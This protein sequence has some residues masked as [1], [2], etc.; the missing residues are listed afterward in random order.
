MAWIFQASLHPGRTYFCWFALLK[1][2]I[3]S[4][5]MRH[6]M[7]EPHNHNW[8]LHRNCL[9]IDGL[10]NSSVLWWSM[11]RPL[12]DRKVVVCVSSKWCMCCSKNEQMEHSHTMVQFS[13]MTPSYAYILQNTVPFQ[14]LSQVHSCKQGRW[15]RNQ[16]H[17]VACHDIYETVILY[18]LI[19][20][21]CTS[22]AFN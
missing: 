8:T 21:R 19:Q 15:Y 5:V 11:K 13:F 16:Y 3:S 10:Y 17:S 2:S 4:H 9:C 20:L 6:L 22:T 7:F 12:K 1:H 14:S 18:A